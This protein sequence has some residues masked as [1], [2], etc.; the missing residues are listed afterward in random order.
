M[1]GLYVSRDWEL[2]LG[3]VQFDELGVGGQRFYWA[4]ANGWEDV[5][6]VCLSVERL[7]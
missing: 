4:V 6:C 5:V 7:L 1:D 3:C 2:G